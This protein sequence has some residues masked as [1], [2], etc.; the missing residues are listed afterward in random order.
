MA[1]ATGVGRDA[2]IN[3][4]S[5]PALFRSFIGAII[6]H[7][8]GSP[9]RHGRQ[10]WYDA[11]TLDRGIAMAIG[12]QTSHHED[13][14]HHHS[15]NSNKTLKRGDKGSDVALLQKYLNLKGAKLKVDTDFGKNTETAVIQF[16]TKNSLVPDGKVGKNTRKALGMP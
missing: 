2:K 13:R 12:Q 9:V 15:A 10:Q 4:R 3:L 7:E 8:N 16:Q 14:S 6:A 11:A 5:N 1:R